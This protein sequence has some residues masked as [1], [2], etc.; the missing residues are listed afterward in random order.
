M[1]LLPSRLFVIVG[2]LFVNYAN[3][4]KESPVNFFKVKPED[5][6]VSKL[7]VDTSQGA[8]IVADIGRSFFEGNSKGWF[9][10]VFEKKTRIHIIDKKGFELAT[11]TVPLYKSKTSDAE[12]RLESLKAYTYNLENGEVVESKLDK[13]Q[14]FKEKLNANRMLKK[15]T[16]PNV[17]NG[18][19]IEYSYIIRSDFLFN[20][21]DWTFQGAYPSM[22]SE[23]NVEMPE[24]FDYV[25]LSQG[26]FPYHIRESKERTQHFTVREQNNA[27]FSRDDVYNLS[28]K[29]TLSKWVVKDIPAMKPESFT[30][31]IKNHLSKLEFQLAGYNFP[32]SPYKKIMSSWE[33]ATSELLKD[34]DF[35]QALSSAN[36]WLSDDLKEFDPKR[37]DKLALAKEIYN[38]VRTN[39][40]NNGYGNI[41]LS[42]PLKQ[43]FKTKTGK[44]QDINI[45][46]TAILNNRGFSAVPVI[47]ST[48]AHGQINEIYPLMNKF[49]YVISKL[50]IGDE[51]FFLDASEPYLGFNRLPDYVYNGG[52]RTVSIPPVLDYFLADSVTETKMTNVVLELDP[53][54]KK[55]WK[56]ILN[57]NLGYSESSNIRESIL[58]NG[59][60]N[61]HKKIMESYTGDIK[62]EGVEFFDLDKYE[63][64]IKVRYDM[65]IDNS[66]N[67]DIIYFS[68]MIKEGMRENV[69]KSADRQYPVEMPYKIDETYIL[70]LVVP[71]GYQIDELPKSARVSFNENE[72][73]FEYLISKTEKDIYLKTS[74]K[75]EKANFPKEDYESLRGFFDYIVKKHAEQ[76]VFKKKS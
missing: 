39:I 14:V 69:F 1:K 64:P 62:V 4:Q 15:F 73:M 53:A 57:S 54:N 5:F 35:G 29:S 46:L 66:S 59:K 49:N 67:A 63:E 65:S 34:D 17:K 32:N 51:I 11:V 52:A 43:T 42:Q 41:Y 10:L 50:K 25:V 68:P 38:W 6:V 7:T 48:R 40:R 76:I 56:G 19:I 74:L 27:A 30:S 3:A 44:S 75:F 71:E 61:N 60:E 28:G 24:F 22:W 8:V 33:T 31:S 12:E 72:G 20:L 55:N 9:S 13:D 16:M 36:N 70:K 21:Q 58:Q 26:Y 18:S 45:L 37:T 23:Y 47:L 2:L